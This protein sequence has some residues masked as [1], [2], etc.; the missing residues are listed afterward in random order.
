[1]YIFISSFSLYIYNICVSCCDICIDMKIIKQERDE[2]DN[3]LKKVTAELSALGV[4]AKQG[5]EAA[6]KVKTLETDNKK[7]TEEN[8]VLTE[9]YN[10]E[11][12]NPTLI[13]VH[14]Y[15]LNT[16]KLS[17]KCFVVYDN[18]SSVFFFICQVLRKKYYNMVEDMKG[19]IRVYCRARPLSSTETGRVKTLLHLKIILIP[20]HKKTKQSA[21]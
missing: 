4:A 6:T 7:L 12:V 2:K 11:R 15:F 10:S 9:N 1:M 19:K 5:M 21:K 3:E 17:P 14:V 20:G 13:I 8:K 18:F 16:S